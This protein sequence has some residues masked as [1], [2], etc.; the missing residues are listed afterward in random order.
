MKRITL[1]VTIGVILGAVPSGSL[2]GQ[3]FPSYYERYSFLAA[4]PSTWGHGLVGFANPATLALLDR[5]EV[6]FLWSSEPGEAW[7]FQ[8]WGLFS[9]FRHFGF[10]VQTQEE[11]GG[12]VTDYKGNPVD[13]YKGEVLGSNGKI[14]REM[15][16]ILNLAMVNNSQ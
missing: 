14:H 5:P 4:P 8:D 11:T 15:I 9:G 13:I 10:S 2:L 7:G 1:R 6:R 16:E 3:T 12:K